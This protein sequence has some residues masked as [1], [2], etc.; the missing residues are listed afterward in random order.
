MDGINKTWLPH[1]TEEIVSEI[2]N[3]FLD[4]YVVAL[5]GWR[6]GLTLTWHVK[7]SEK[8]QQMKTWSVDEPGQLFSLHSAERSHYFF[9]TRGDKVSNEAV[10]QGMNKEITKQILS[11][12]GVSVPE[13]REFTENAKEEDVIAYANELGYPVVL[14]P[15]DGSFG[16]GVMANITT[17]EECKHALDYIRHELEE[18]NIIVEKYIDG[19]DYRLYV[20]DEEVVGAILRIPPNITGDGMNSIDALI[21]IKNKERGLNP[22]LSTTLIQVNQELVDYIGRSGYTLQTIPE[23]GELIYLSDKSNISIGGDPIDVLDDLSDEMKQLA[24]NALQAIP[25]LTHGAVDLMI[26]TTPDGTENGYIIELNPTAQLG[27]ILF[28]LKGTPRDVPKAIIDYYFPETKDVDNSTNH[29]YFDYKKV[30]TPLYSNLAKYVVIPTLDTNQFQ[31]KKLTITGL[32]QGVDDERSIKRI[33]LQYHVYGI[34]HTLEK[35]ETEIIIAGSKK[36][37][38]LFTTVLRQTIQINTMHEQPWI[39]PLQATFLLKDGKSTFI[40][41]INN[42]KKQRAQLQQEEKQLQK[43]HGQMLSSTSWR[44][45]LPLRK[46]ASMVKNNRCMNK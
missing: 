39:K 7:D 28:P 5:E 24:I 6:R 46:I 19:A 2:E 31:S 20:V 23:R 35:R 10:E 12:K 17:D 37:I 26:E 34:I 21:D 43:R 3:N 9:R 45:T 40:K 41:K 30:L 44:I 14:K 38:E 4:A 8:F 33:A 32:F 22:R 16:R 25:G 27:G 11:E 42:Q 29:M 1:L 15:T 36:N 18:T 13:G